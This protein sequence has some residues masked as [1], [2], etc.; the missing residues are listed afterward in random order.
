[1]VS[2]RP[3]ECWNVDNE[4]CS[5]FIFTMFFFWLGVKIR[6]HS[7][8]IFQIK[9]HV[10]EKLFRR[11]QFHTL[12]RLIAMAQAH[13]LP[14]LSAAPESGAQYIN[15]LKD[16]LVQN[17][18]LVIAIPTFTAEGNA[19]SVAYLLGTYPSPPP[20]P[21][22]VSS[23]FGNVGSME[24]GSTGSGLQNSH[25]FS[26]NDGTNIDISRMLTNHDLQYQMWQKHQ[27]QRQ[28]EGGS[29]GSSIATESITRLSVSDAFGG[30]NEVEDRP[31]PS[32]QSAPPPPPPP[33]NTPM[34]H[35]KKVEN[36]EVTASLKITARD[37]NEYQTNM[38]GDDNFG[39]FDSVPRKQSYESCT[40]DTQ[41]NN[42]DEVAAKRD[43][44]NDF[45]VFKDGD[46]MPSGVV[47]ISGDN[48]IES[49]AGHSS[50]IKHDHRHDLRNDA[51]K[52]VGTFG[53]FSNGPVPF[54]SAFGI[55]GSTLTVSDAFSSLAVEHGPCEASESTSNTNVV[56]TIEDENQHGTTKLETFWGVEENNFSKSSF[57]PESENNNHFCGS[58]HE[59]PSGDSQVETLPPP[60]NFSIN[61]GIALQSFRNDVNKG[62]DIN[63]E[64]QLNGSSSPSN[65]KD[66]MQHADTL[67]ASS[68]G[69]Q[70]PNGNEDHFGNFE[71]LHNGNNFSQSNTTSSSTFHIFGNVEDEPSLP[72][73][74]IPSSNQNSFVPSEND[75][76]G[77][78]E[79]TRQG[80][81]LILKGTDVD[82]FDVRGA[83]EFGDFEST[84]TSYT[85]P[86]QTEDSAIVTHNVTGSFA[87]YGGIHDE[88]FS[89]ICA[90]S[91]QKENSPQS[92]KTDHV[93]G[94]FRD[95]KSNDYSMDYARD[96]TDKASAITSAFDVF[97]DIQDAPLPPLGGTFSSGNTVISKPNENCD[98]F[99]DVEDT[100][101]GVTSPKFASE[102]NAVTL[103]A[104]SAIA[105]FG[106][107]E[108]SVSNEQRKTELDDIDDSFDHV[109]SAPVTTLGVSPTNQ[110]NASVHE[111]DDEFGDFEGV[112]NDDASPDP[113]DGVDTVSSESSSPFDAFGDAQNDPLP[114]LGG[115][116]DSNE[117]NLSK[118]DE[119][120]NDF[121]DFEG[122]TNYNAGPVSVNNVNNFVS[123][124]ASSD[125]QD[126]SLPPL[127]GLSAVNEQHTIGPDNI[128]EGTQNDD[129]APDSVTVGV[130]AS[131][132]KSSALLAFGDIQDAP[133]PP[134]DGVAATDEHYGTKPDELGG[135]FGVFEGSRKDVAA[136]DSVKGTNLVSVGE[137]SAFD[138][139]GDAPDTPL[140]PLGHLSASNGHH[141]INPDEI[142][143]DFGDF[144]DTSNH[145]GALN[146]I[147]DINVAVRD[148]PYVFDAFSSGQDASLPPLTGLSTSNEPNA[149]RPDEIDDDFGDFEGVKNGVVA[150]DSLH[151]TS[152]VSVGASSAC[153]EISDVQNAPLP[154]YD[155]SSVSN[156]QH[157]TEPDEFGG[158]SGD[159]EPKKNNHAG[160]DAV[161]NMNAA[162]V[163]TSSAFIASG[164]SQVATP[165]LVGELS[166]KNE[167]P[168]EP[169]EF[170]GDPGDFEST[171]NGVVA[172]DSLN[173]KNLAAASSAFDA[174]CEIQDEPLQPLGGLSATNEQNSTAYD[175]I[176]NDFGDFE[177]TKVD[178]ADP[179]TSNVLNAVSVAATTA[180][181]A[182]GDAQVAPL[183]SLGGFSVSNEQNTIQ[184]DESGNFG[185]FEGT[186]NHD[187]AP[188]SSN[189]ANVVSVDASSAID[190][191]S[192]DHDAPLSSHVGLAASNEKYTTEPDGIDDD[193]LDFA[194]TNNDKVAPD[195]FNYVNSV[196]VDAS[197]AFDA[198]G[199][200]QVSLLPSLGG[201][202]TS[203]EQNAKDPDENEDEF[204]DFEGTNNVGAGPDSL[205]DTNAVLVDASSLFDAFRDIQ[206]APL[207]PPRH[208]FASNQEQDAEP[209]KID[210]KFC[211][212]ENTQINT[213][214]PIENLGASYP[215]LSDSQG[216]RSNQVGFSVPRAS[217]GNQNEEILLQQHTISEFNAFRDASIQPLSG[218][219]STSSKPVTNDSDFDEF[220]NPKPWNTTLESSDSECSRNNDLPPSSDKVDEYLGIDKKAPSAESISNDSNGITKLDKDDE[221]FGVCKI[222]NSHGKTMDLYNGAL[223]V[224][225]DASLA[226][227][228]VEDFG[229]FEGF[230]SNG[231]VEASIDGHNLV[232][233][234]T[235][236]S[237]DF[238][239]AQKCNSASI[240]CSSRRVS[241]DDS[242]DNNPGRGKGGVNGE[243]NLGY[244]ATL[245]G[246]HK[247]DE[248]FDGPGDVE[249][250]GDFSGF[251][252]SDD[253]FS[254]ENNS[255]NEKDH[256]SLDK[257][258]SISH[259]ASKG[260]GDF[261]PYGSSD[262]L[263][264]SGVKDASGH[265]DDWAGF[266][267]VK[268]DPD[269]STNAHEIFSHLRK[270]LCN[271]KGLDE[272][273]HNEG[274]CDVSILE[275]FDKCVARNSENMEAR[276]LQLERCIFLSEQIANENC[277]IYQQW[278]IIISNVNDDL[279]I[280]TRVLT[281]LSANREKDDSKV[282]LRSRK[283]R[284]YVVGLS[285]CVRLLRFITATIGDLLCVD[286]CFD[287]NS[288][289]L[290]NWYNHRLIA[291]AQVIEEL[292]V[293]LSSTAATIGL[294]SKS[295]DLERVTDIRAR[296]VPI[297]SA[298][299]NQR[300]C[301][302]TLQPLCAS[303]NESSHTDSVVITDKLYMACAAH[304]WMKRLKNKLN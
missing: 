263:S 134:L 218:K 65:D 128:F 282:I 36:T 182:F 53:R 205:N 235:L 287:F 160:T 29:M 242:G 284:N 125:A 120:E 60:D 132:D 257:E 217:I 9:I 229:G 71:V 24:M 101:D 139:F 3:R 275:C 200:A 115:F 304:Y 77:H 245:V 113:V 213:D 32:L 88:R 179:N 240:L 236:V 233:Q 302:L 241:D 117:Q 231:A 156:E 300:F 68:G 228:K 192:D 148:V 239:N 84:Q 250:F 301:H 61:N 212:F 288:G 180:F 285:E 253:S 56:R 165:F 277:S 238:G 153:N 111:F 26:D 169:D 81:S 270:R 121:G 164:D 278:K 175:E 47:T 259:I 150:I 33:R 144:E 191:F 99:G 202:S 35:D 63:H 190:A 15:L 108:M 269:Q 91:I 186:S 97:G 294:L 51:G 58:E 34:Y 227:N 267:G 27:Q 1:M 232:A 215:I 5:Y 260:I 193:F 41:C 23:G 142:D 272:I 152:V 21:T 184:P 72:L 43:N 189:V 45:N 216:T 206:D 131:V 4:V 112:K 86:Q 265:D 136:P 110:Q 293:G 55:S 252:S 95:T 28:S 268:Q 248:V 295:P 299:T 100:I 119:C 87:E 44:S 286:I 174:L 196:A 172:I 220:I 109:Q 176:D 85:T 74:R 161:S 188:E 159:F 105:E 281:Y 297:D 17:A 31:L 258:D 141:A 151:E 147:N 114:P 167:Q 11:S 129:A 219:F 146:S 93:F 135:N 283:L 143:D 2:S 73:G 214:G 42:H 255:F 207:P 149:A 162:S 50:K 249:D 226:S 222:T 46:M 133:L 13:F 154:P 261:S 262:H 122:M 158:G 25:V 199:D 38:E 8:T 102:D 37:G 291:E 98:D 171:N 208:S 30:L 145:E 244:N 224:S 16:A 279:Q 168:I 39:D 80:N 90:F 107:I 83:D 256:T 79:G 243:G 104:S 64:L 7:V 230:D 203:N 264:D 78:N 76:I 116:T 237:D 123:V 274:D 246:E 124:V 303:G 223:P 198:F 106:D 187:A 178:H 289:T 155:G 10:N 204:G 173:G 75:D 247:L 163:E 52:S 137:C 22:P 197:S 6:F 181:D 210:C 96:Q 82:E 92:S 126:A 69:V 170:G 19:P 183:P 211:E 49:K 296:V 57:D 194:G 273:L 67:P 209:D 12:L 48:D 20:A 221:V 280:G 59:V 185:D 166:T 177:G 251:P 18:H 225:M 66:K 94:G 127:G 138:S 140:P 266:E 89:P 195:S 70:A 130:K 201:F 118:P 157:A 254:K 271:L 54:Q 40:Q 14:P 234:D 276:R 292:W 298:S 290:N 62:V 103:D